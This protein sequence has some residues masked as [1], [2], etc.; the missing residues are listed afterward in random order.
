MYEDPFEYNILL[1][2]E[3]LEN[4]RVP[5]ERLAAEPSKE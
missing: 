3:A 5:D 1:L 4:D 2:E